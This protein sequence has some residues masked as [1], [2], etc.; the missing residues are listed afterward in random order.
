MIDQNKITKIHILAYQGHSEREISQ[1]LKIS[2]TT[3]NKYLENPL[4]TRKS[5][6]RPSKLKPYFGI[7]D[8]FIENHPG[9]SAQETYE[10]LQANGFDGGIT[11][12]RD[13]LARIIGDILAEH[14]KKIYLNMIKAELF[15]CM[16]KRDSYEKILTK[17][18]PS[19]KNFTFKL[20]LSEKER[21]LVNIAGKNGNHKIW[22]YGVA[23][24][25]KGA[26]FSDYNIAYIL[27]LDRRTLNNIKK[28]F[29]ANG[30]EGV[31]RRKTPIRNIKSERAELKTKRIIE[32]VHHSP[33]FFGLNRSSWTKATISKVYEGKYCERISETTV[34]DRLKNSGYS[35][36]KARNVLK[37]SDPDYREK[38]DLLLKI[39]HSLKSYEIF[40]FIDEIG[41]MR[42][43][44]YGGRSYSR[45]GEYKKVPNNQSSKGSIIFSSA[46]SATTN[47][48][49]WVYSNAKDS[50]SMIDLIEILYNQNYQ[51]RK[52]YITWDA[53]SWH[54]SNELV[55]WLDEFNAATINFGGGPIIEFIPLPSCSQFLNIIE[56]VFSHMKKA[57]IHNSNYQSKG[58][59]KSAISLHFVERNDYFK[60]NPKRAGK[61]IWEIDF[62]K[63]YNNIKSGDYREW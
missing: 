41:P 11:I 14:R 38:V 31:L 8:K 57:V 21:V 4:Q 32:I 49:S 51:K 23:I 35:L 56:S 28:K 44:K 20:L 60:K 50:S 55:E 5:V 39:L 37:S 13:Y 10:Y 1:K 19:K 27:D 58:E 53:A 61:K 18:L 17:R 9:A 45:K 2:R 29:D 40:F 63:D 3:V 22:R 59:M 16:V 33:R 54:R 25:M 52:I 15:K 6:D 26:G 30:F 24:D 36:K 12:V 62:F 42:V 34:G 46:L 7:I 47:Q 43:K 48:L